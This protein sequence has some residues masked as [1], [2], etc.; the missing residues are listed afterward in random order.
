MLDNRWRR[1]QAVPASKGSLPFF[2]IDEESF[3]AQSIL[4][5][6]SMTLE[7]RPIIALMKRMES[8]ARR[9]SACR[10]RGRLHGLRGLVMGIRGREVVESMLLGVLE[11]GT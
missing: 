1:Y 6:K 10:E 4:L 8:H 5:A 7:E 3:V 2:Y 11:A 9:G